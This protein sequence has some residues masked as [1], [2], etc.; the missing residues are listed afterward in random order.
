MLSIAVVDFIYIGYGP[1][2]IHIFLAALYPLIVLPPVLLLLAIEEHPNRIIRVI[3]SMNRQLRV[4]L[5]A[6]R[7]RRLPMS[8]LGHITQRLIFY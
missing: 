5:R 1:V 7:G 4:T 2:V 3:L 8:V 6:E